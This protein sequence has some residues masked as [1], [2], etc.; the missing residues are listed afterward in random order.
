METKRNLG[1]SVL[2][3]CLLAVD[4]SGIVVVVVAVENWDGADASLDCGASDSFAVGDVP[5]FDG[6]TSLSVAE[7]L[8][9]AFI[10]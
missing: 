2:T 8:S 10:S 9:F 1:T 5:S 4:V 3:E 6:G 7:A